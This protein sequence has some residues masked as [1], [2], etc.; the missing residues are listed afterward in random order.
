VR[1]ILCPVDF[2][3]ATARQVD[4]AAALCRVFGARLVLHYNVSA[5]PPGLGVSWMWTAEH[6]LV[7]DHAAA[8]KLKALQ[9]GISDVPTEILM[10]KGPDLASVLAASEQVDADLVVLSTHGASTLDHASVTERILER[11]NRAILV[12]H[13]SNGEGGFVLTSDPRPIV[14]VPADLSEEA[15]PAVAFAVRLAHALPVELHLLQVLPKG[16]RARADADLEGARRDLRAFVPADLAARVTTD[17][18]RR[19][20]ADGIVEAAIR[21]R[22]A[23]IVMG[24]HVRA[25]RGVL[26]KAPCP[27][28]YVPKHRGTL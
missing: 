14:I 19:D 3:A 18:E 10:T 11:G 4:A 22:A 8:D 25:S 12:L 6:P 15:R 23:C 21:L 5:L 26:R 17:V 28:W 9:Q 2:S 24:E 16:H 7:S 20:D 27:V 13:G 1:T